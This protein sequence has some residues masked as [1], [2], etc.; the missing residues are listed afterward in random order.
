MK[1]STLITVLTRLTTA[2]SIVAPVV[3]FGFLFVLAVQPKRAAADAAEK[4]VE[5][6]RAELARRQTIAAT[7]PAPTPVSALADF[8]MRTAAG[9]RSGDFADAISKLVSGSAVGGVTGL[10]IETGV[11]SEARPTSRA[12]LF[13]PGIVQTPLT[14]SFDA[15]YE[16]TGRFFWNLRMLPTTFELRSVELIPGSPG[17]GL[18]RAKTEL[19]AF[20]R[21]A[22]ASN[23]LPHTAAPSVDLTTVPEWKRDPFAVG[24]RPKARAIRVAD[25]PEQPEVSSIL[26]SSGRRVAIVDG[27]IVHAGDRV[28]TGVVQS[29]ERDAVLITTDGRQ[30]RRVEVERQWH[31]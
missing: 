19:V 27:R 23:P 9:D 8:E 14:V 10:S 20:H 18:M 21:S 2:L 31:P 4:L 24:P 7:P 11:P 12:V 22:V 29:I 30:T 13:S 3:V 16:Q 1:S 26:F 17:A 28:R 15:S 25:E 6:A 5:T